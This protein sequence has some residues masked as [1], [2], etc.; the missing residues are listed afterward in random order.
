MSLDQVFS[1]RPVPHHADY[2]TPIKGMYMCG[3]ACHPG[4]GVTGVPG[5]NAAREILA[6]SLSSLAKQVDAVSSGHEAIAAIKERDADAPYDVVFMDWQMPGMD[7]LDVARRIKA[8]SRIADTKIILLTSMRQAGIAPEALAAGVNA[9][10][11]KPTRQSQLFDCIAQLVVA[12]VYSRTGAQ[13]QRASEKPT[14]SKGRVLVAELN[15]GQMAMILR[16]RFALDATTCNNNQARP[17]EVADLVR[18]VE[19][20]LAR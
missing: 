7:G 6:E 11:A 9:C 5:H 19:S 20:A 8:D 3:A 13:Q 12:G 14:T 4:G 2:R 15:S 10:L 18:A 1:R 17:F 16:A